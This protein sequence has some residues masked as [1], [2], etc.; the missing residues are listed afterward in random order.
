[1]PLR[2]SSSAECCDV[3]WA[4]T[5]AEFQAIA[6]QRGVV[7]DA[8]EAEAELRQ[9]YTLIRQYGAI[10]ENAMRSAIDLCRQYWEQVGPP[11]SQTREESFRYPPQLIAAVR[12]SVTEVMALAQQAGVSLGDRATV[13]RMLTAEARNTFR[14]IVGFF[15]NPVSAV[16]NAVESARRTAE[17]QIDRKKR[18][19]AR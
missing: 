10:H 2:P 19:G 1:M 3:D 12:M 4:P 17:G 7:F 5:L 9:K 18:D 16:P 11:A 6:R 15:P 8:R 14:Q 13:L